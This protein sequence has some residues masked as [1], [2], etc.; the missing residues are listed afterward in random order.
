MDKLT[1]EQKDQ[2]KNMIGLKGAM[3]KAELEMVDKKATESLL[4]DIKPGCDFMFD[5]FDLRTTN[6]G[7]ETKALVQAKTL[8]KKSPAYQAA[9]A[10]AE[11]DALGACQAKC[12]VPDHVKCK[13]CVA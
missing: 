2:Q 1:K 11:A 3:A 9:S 7:K 10:E 4:A 12:S 8:M 13:A 6:R 5:N